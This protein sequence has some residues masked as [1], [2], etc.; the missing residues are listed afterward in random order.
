M[1]GYSGAFVAEVNILNLRVAHC[2]C[3]SDSGGAVYAATCRGNMRINEVTF[4]DNNA[5][6]GSGGALTLAS[7]NF[8]ISAS[9]FKGA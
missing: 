1:I 9:V 4:T 3:R 7:C 5:S 2:R 8:A 6:V